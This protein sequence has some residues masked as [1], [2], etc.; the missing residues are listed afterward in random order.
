M[1]RWHV[2][3]FWPELN[4]QQ[5]KLPVDIGG[6]KTTV[7]ELSNVPLSPTNYYKNSFSYS[8]AIL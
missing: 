4:V 5:H 8:G 3:I 6:S 7:L 1:L 2:A